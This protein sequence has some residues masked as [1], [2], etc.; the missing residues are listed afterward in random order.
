M[1]KAEAAKLA[2]FCG[3]CRLDPVRWS[4]EAFPWSTPGGP[5]D[6]FTGPRTW[7]DDTLAII[8]DHLKNKQTRYQPLRIAIASGHGI[9]KSALIGMLVSWALGCWVDSRVQITA[10]TEGQLNTKTSPEVG[11]WVKRSI[12]A[13]LFT[14]GTESIKRADKKHTTNWRADFIT[15]SESNPAAFAGLHNAGKLIM[16]VMDEASGIPTVIWQTAQGAM[17]DADTVMIWLAFGNPLESS[18]SFAD[19]FGIDKERW[20]TRNIDNRTVEGVNVAEQQAIVDKYGE[21]S[22]IARARVRGLF[23][24]GSIDSLFGEA[25]I[26]AAMARQLPFGSQDRAAVILGV[27]VARQGDDDSVI[28]M[29]QGLNADIKRRL[30][31]ADGVLVANSVSN[32]E[33]EF[34]VDGTLI[35]M[36][37]GYGGS[38]YDQLVT[39]NRSPI[40][41]QFAAKSPQPERFVNMRAYMYWLFA[42]WVKNGGKL[43]FCPSLKRQ[44]LATKYFIKSGKMQLIDKEDIKKEI[45]QSPDD[46]DAIALTFAVPV[47]KKP[48][49]FMRSNSQTA[50]DRQRGHDP[51]K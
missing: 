25:D 3:L 15:W 11:A 40:P 48:P 36:T 24:I 28:A 22:D 4:N 38:V 12:I 18:G 51:F 9:G 42:E 44:L 33:D 1:T 2:K 27:D 49:G 30:S 26:D 46:A 6:K 17:T 14:I 45:G 32:L 23:P 37:G 21:D 7:Q 29:R 10:N 35:D 8:R 50:A 5:L 16:I 34:D 13:D 41:I 19:C 47:A 43:P 39:Q 20:V 31:G